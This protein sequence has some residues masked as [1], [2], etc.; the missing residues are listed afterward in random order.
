MSQ[1]KDVLKLCE[2]LS[3]QYS[4][5]DG[6][7]EVYIKKDGIKIPTQHHIGWRI[8]ECYYNPDD[9]VSLPADANITLYAFGSCCS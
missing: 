2:W 7:K 6:K 8:F 3:A 5:S 4:Y 9:F 1:K